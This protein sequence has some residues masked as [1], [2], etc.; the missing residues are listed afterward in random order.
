GHRRRRPASSS[1]A[2][3]GGGGV[4]SRDRGD[5]SDDP[6]GRVVL[7]LD[8]DCFYAQCEVVRLG[9]D[10]SAPLALVQ[11]RSA[12]AVNYPARKFG[13]K[14][15]DSFEVIQQKSKGEC[16]AIH[17]PVTPVTPV[18]DVPASSGASPRC[19]DGGGNGGGEDEG[20]SPSTDDDDGEA[21]ASPSAYDE[22]F[23]QPQHVRDEMYRREKN[24]MRSQSEGKACLD[25]YRLASSRIFSLIDETLAQIL[26]RKNFILER[27]SIDELFIDVTAFCRPSAT[28]DDVDGGG[29]GDGD[30][31][32]SDATT[33][34]RE[35]CEEG[36]VRSL[37]ETAICHDERL[38]ADEKDDEVGRA[39]R[40]GCHVART[41][42]RAVFDELGFTLSAGI[43][44]SKLVSKLAASYGKPNG[45]AVIFPGAMAKVMEETQISKTR[46]LGGKLGKRVQSLLPESETTMGSVARLLPLDRLEEEIGE[47]SGRWVFDACRGID[48]E[49]VRA[50]L[51]VL[52][53]SITAFKSFPKVSYPELEK[54]TAL[55]A[56]D[57]MKRVETDNARNNRI[58]KSVT[59]GYTMV[60][61]GAWIG[62][63]FRLPFP[64]DR[65]FDARVQRLVDSTRRV[66]T[67]RGHSSFIRIGLSAIDFVVRARVGIDSFFRKGEALKSS[68]KRLLGSG[69]ASNKKAAAKPGGIND[70]FLSK[71]AQ[72][73]TPRVIASASSPR[74]SGCESASQN[75]L[76]PEQLQ[77][78]AGS[79]DKVG[80]SDP[81]EH[82]SSMTDEE[83]ARRLQ[84]SYDD[85]AR[86]LGRDY[87]GASIVG[88]SV[89]RDKAFALQLQSSYDREHSVLSHVERF[90]G[91]K[92]H[93]GAANSKKKEV[94]NKRSKID[95]FLKK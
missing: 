52:P 43:S 37:G 55:L 14:R 71:S 44:T 31:K 89:D 28:S 3:G 56:R 90:S 6:H 77:G 70:Y 42:R 12:L 24:R 1:L 51:R 25:R 57:V 91:R 38:H 64:T 73:A 23:H 8:M 36:A 93:L 20:A 83:V 34:F 86:G 68:P 78:E 60:P 62:R 35:G 47:E 85:E 21:D 17:L 16:A 72:P 46:L 7:L 82:S 13:I 49:A 95:Y 69:D 76:P 94:V 5:A 92:S 48:H 79:I 66:L 61:G 18:D 74:P 22:E 40:L 32:E 26:G 87:S 19:G 33:N 2:G 53:K 75:T 59:V 39:L 63:T 11:W 58:P 81:A 41:V 10:P 45:Q 88:G 15:G 27:A 30:G 4:A 65:D 54:W 84:G 29:D 67:E 50:T 9:L 80:D